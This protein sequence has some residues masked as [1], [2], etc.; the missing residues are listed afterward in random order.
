M[1]FNFDQG[2]KP[3]IKKKQMHTEKDSLRPVEFRKSFTKLWREK[4]Q[5]N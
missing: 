3:I 1:T 4:K 5:G 2:E